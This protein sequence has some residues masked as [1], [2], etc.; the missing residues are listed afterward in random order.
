ML[1]FYSILSFLIVVLA[2]PDW[3]SLGCILAAALGYAIFWKGMLFAKR[4]KSRFLLATIWFASV[5]AV[6]LS[7]FWSDRYV[8]GYI[9]IFLTLLILALGMQFAFISLFIA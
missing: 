3:S 5:Q 8:G 7:W 9:F 4:Y 1:V 2:Q 6:H